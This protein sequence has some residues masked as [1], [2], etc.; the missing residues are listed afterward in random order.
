MTWSE[1]NIAKNVAA[2]LLLIFYTCEKIF[3]PKGNNKST[4][5]SSFIDIMLN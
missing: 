5:L 4:L 3:M 2:S 1:N